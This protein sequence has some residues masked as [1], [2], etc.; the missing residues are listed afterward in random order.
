MKTLIRFFLPFALT[1]ADLHAQ[2][3]AADSAAA[4]FK[5]AKTKLDDK[6]DALM[7]KKQGD[8]VKTAKEFR[9]EVEALEARYLPTMFTEVGAAQKA[10]DTAKEEALKKTLQDIFKAKIGVALTGGKL[11]EIP[12]AGLT[13]VGSLVEGDRIQLQ[14]IC[15]TWNV[16]P[17]AP[18]VSPDETNTRECNIK[19]LHKAISGEETVIASNIKHTR[20]KPYEHDV[21]IRGN[22]FLVISGTVNNAHS[23][24]TLYRV[25]AEKK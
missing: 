11:L 7:A 6:Y 17:P 3:P 25:V 21:E 8:K 10:G 23:G 4:A 9:K 18:M 16:Y 12:C 19:L 24:K 5:A 22:Y 14:Y 2:T 1:L 15:G 13:K 20:E